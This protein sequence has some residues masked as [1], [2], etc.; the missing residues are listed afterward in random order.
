MILNN[1]SIADIVAQCVHTKPYRA[2]IVAKDTKIKAALDQLK[3]ALSA[4]EMGF[5]CINICPQTYMFCLSNGSTIEVIDNSIYKGTEH[6]FHLVA[7]D[8][9]GVRIFNA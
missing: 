8:G 6:R 9:A 1:N 4:N 7:T 2:A 5:S 3:A